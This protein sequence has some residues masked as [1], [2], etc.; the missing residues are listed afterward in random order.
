MISKPKFVKKAN[1]F[2][3]TER[4]DSSDLKKSKQI[5]YWFSTF[6]EAQEKY[7]ELFFVE[8]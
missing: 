5:Q 8:K 4:N 2:V 7:L 6:K 3:I 1:Q